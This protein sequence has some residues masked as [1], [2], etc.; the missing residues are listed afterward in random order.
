MKRGRKKA[1]LRAIRDGSNI[2]TACKKAGISRNTYYRW[3]I[4]D[5]TFDFEVDKAFDEGML[6]IND[7][8]EN[9]LLKK[10]EEGNLSAIKYRLGRM[11]PGYRKTRTTTEGNGIKRTVE[12][13]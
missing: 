7:F 5:P 13:V 8:T 3:S 4:E 2:T 1:L 10:I 12:E 11:Y 6:V 9:Q